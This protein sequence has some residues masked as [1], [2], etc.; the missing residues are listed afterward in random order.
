MRMPSAHFKCNKVL[1]LQLSQ[2]CIRSQCCNTRLVGLQGYALSGKTPL[3]VASYVEA[4]RDITNMISGNVVSINIDPDMMQDSLF[5]M[6]PAEL[7]EGVMEEFKWL[8]DNYSPPE[9]LSHLFDRKEIVIKFK[10]AVQKM[11]RQEILHFV[12][13]NKYNGGA[14]HPPFSQGKMWRTL[15][16]DIKSSARPPAHG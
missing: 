12:G 4:G 8:K 14:M 11:T 16:Y 5:E 3:M 13:P 10:E 6:W 15:L 7:P 9:R 2:C 1:A